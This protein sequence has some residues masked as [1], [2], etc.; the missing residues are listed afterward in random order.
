MQGEIRSAIEAA[1]GELGISG[2]DFVV[3]HPWELSHGD[4]A[5]NVALVAAKQAGENPRQFAEQIAAVL[6]GKLE[7][8]EQIDIA[9]PGF[10][11]FHL[12]R[13]FYKNEINRV[14][15]EGDQWGRNETLKGQRIMVE[16]TQPNPFKVFHIGHLMSNAIGESL[17]RLVE[18]SGAETFRANYQGDVGLHIG[19]TMWALEKLGYDPEDT[20]KV[21]EAYA[22]GHTQYESDEEAKAEI[23]AMTKAV[24]AKDPNVMEVYEK[25]RA[26]SLKHFEAIYARVGTKFDHLFF[27]GDV[28]Q[29]GKEVVEAHIGDV[30]EESDGAIVYKGE[31]DGLHTRVFI[32]SQ[33]VTTYEAKDVGLAFAKR[34]VWEFDTNITV[35]AVEQDQ[36]FKVVFSAIAKVDEWFNGKLTNVAHGMMTLS[37]GKMSSRKGNVITGESMLDDA[38]A[39]AYEKIKDN[40]ELEDKEALA[41]TIGVAALKY[42]ILKQSLGKN[43]VYDMERALSFEGDSGPYLQYTYARINSVLEKAAAAGLI[44]TSGPDTAAA[45]ATPYEIEKILYRFPE[46][47]EEATAER[48]PHKVAT[49]LT[50]L[51]GEFNTFYGQEKIADPSDEHAPYKV[52]VAEAVKQTL[53]NGLWVLGIKAP[54]RM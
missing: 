31:Q 9:G 52:A 38:K 2:I 25:G 37:D 29:K 54:E 20:A 33:G 3:E 10:L 4:Y 50:Q 12:K 1:T 6:D 15:A 47:I 40:T 53:E 26:A 51:A 49:Y 7:Q 30:F 41:D 5:S 34:D 16:Y 46:V 17:S 32:N 14:T 11:N 13:D 36:Y 27:E 19:K 42:L 22:Y 35:T 23:V 21:G 39:A 45:P 28:W 48:E 43:I 18:F 8:V 44:N 24:Y